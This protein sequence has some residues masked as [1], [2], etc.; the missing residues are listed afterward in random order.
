[1]AFVPSKRWKLPY[2]TTSGGFRSRKS[3]TD[4]AEEAKNLTCV[5]FEEFCF[6]LLRR[7]GFSNLDWRKGTPKDSSPADSGRDIV[8]HQQREDV[9]GSRFF[10]VWFVDCKHYN[11]AIPPTEL[12]NALAWADAES[13]DVLLFI[14]SGYFSNPAKEYLEKYRQSRKPRFRIKVWELPQI[15]HFTSGRRS[16]LYRYDLLEEKHKIRSVSQIRKAENEFYEKLWYGRALVW[17]ELGMAGPMPD[18]VMRRGTNPKLRR[19]FAQSKRQLEKKYGKKNLTPKD[20][21]EWGVFN[22]KLSAL[23]WVLGDEWDTLDSP[24]WGRKWDTL[25][26]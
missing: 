17:P 22:G 20:Q 26:T 5:V 1:M 12:Q 10:D 6:E 25:D 14:A 4:S 18:S 16:L 2:I 19:I 15:E 9:D 24:P 23:R 13:P 8:A 21:F 3:P 7:V 11:K